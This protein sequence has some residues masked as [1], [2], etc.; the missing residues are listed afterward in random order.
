MSGPTVLLVAAEASGDTLGASLARAMRA[1]APGARFVGVGG[2]KMA[3]E[4]VE[5]PFDIAEL[6]VLGLLEGLAAYPKVVRRVRETVALAAREKPDIAVLIDSWGFTLRVAQGLRKLDP[7]LPLVKYVGPQVWASRPGRART[8]A[9]TV[10][11]LLSIHGFDA[12]Y[13]EAEG[14]KTIPVGNPALARDFSGADAARLRARLRVG[15]KDPILLILPGSRPGEIK[16]L[17]EPLGEAALRLKANRPNLQLVIPVAAPVADLVRQETAA[18]AVQPVLIEDEAGK[19]DAFVGATAALACSGTVTTELALAGCPMVV[20]YR[21]GHVTHAILKR[22]IRTRYITLFNVAAGREIAPELVQ[23]ACT[24][25]ALA[26]A[27]APLLDDPARRRM[28]AE[29]QAA[30][31]DLMGRGQGDPSERAAEAVLALLA[32][33]GNGRP[34]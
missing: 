16:R 9:A 23:D 5:S 12:P 31:L 10:D 11:L 15:P 21:L 20:C 4:G 14:L 22:L 17:A 34:P 8:L 32:E 25:E 30:A 6:S 7:D 2:P 18:W 27:A 26:S 1:R 3:I 13:F 19:A 24:P 29:Q 33:R 28:Q